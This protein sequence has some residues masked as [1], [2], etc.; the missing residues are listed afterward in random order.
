M[1]I[2]QKEEEEEEENEDYIPKLR[3]LGK[4]KIR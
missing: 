4:R 1:N 3:M 2:S